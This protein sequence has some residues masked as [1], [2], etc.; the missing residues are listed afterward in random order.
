MCTVKVKAKGAGSAGMSTLIVNGKKFNIKLC[1][2]KTA[3]EFRKLLP[4]KITMDELNGNEK[5][6][7]MDK[8]LT[9]S[10][11]KIKNI[12]TG[13]VMLYGDDC[14]VVFYADFTTTYQYTRIGHITNTAALAHALGGGSVVVNLENKSE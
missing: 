14:L 3:K 9:S 12:K 10:P 1:A 4:M 7:Y 11:E 5:Y 2:N 6:F 13:D 8:K